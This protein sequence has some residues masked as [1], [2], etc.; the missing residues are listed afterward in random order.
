M[1]SGGMIAFDESTCM[2][3]LARFFLE[4][5]QKESCGKCTSCRI[6]TLRMLEIL[7]RIVEGKGM[8]GDTDLLLDLGEQIKSTAQCGLGKPLRTLF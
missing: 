3:E 2:V 5:T 8:D 6:G 7:E 1:G 4:F